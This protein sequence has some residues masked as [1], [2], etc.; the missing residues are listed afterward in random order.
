MIPPQIKIGIAIAII[1][2][3]ALMGWRLHAAVERN[4]KLAAELSH[5]EQQVR[6]LAGQMLQR[7][8]EAAQDI[9]ARDAATAEAR[10][11]AAQN[12]AR[13]ATL[14]SQLED[15]RHDSDLSA[16]LDMRLPDTVRLP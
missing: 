13:A 8:R 3:L 12:A 5:A 1:A 16:C 4:G 14:A 11:Q 6:T 15:A 9:A 7:Q 10:R 2:A